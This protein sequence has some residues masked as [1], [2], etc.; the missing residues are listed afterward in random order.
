MVFGSGGVG[1]YFGARLAQAG[2][3]VG[4]VARGAHLA[5]LRAQGLRVLSPLGEL[6]L[7]RVEASDDPTELPEPELVLV[8]V[9][10]W[11]VPEAAAALRGVVRE[12]TAVLPLQN[13]VE[14]PEQLMQVLGPDAVLGGLCRIIAYLEAPGVIR[15]LGVEPSVTFGELDDRRSERVATLEALWTSAGVTCE[16]PA[17]IVT[18]MW[19]KFLLIA[20]WS[21]VGAVTR[22]P[23]GVL[24]ALPETRALLVDC[25]REVMAVAQARGVALG[26]DTVERTLAF[27]DAAPPDGTSSMQRDIMEGRPSELEA[28][29]GAVVRLGALAGVPT[30]VNRVIYA[31]LRPLEARARGHLGF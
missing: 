18:A 9:K 22:A 11:Q 14:A 23:I 29:T 28:Q 20:S 12:G 1:G 25:M 6:H 15:H 30:P 5:A 4:F 3:R 8:A 24:R 7:E 2:H 21:G 26:A 17:S 31:A 19:E 10:T 13:G 27:G 16:V